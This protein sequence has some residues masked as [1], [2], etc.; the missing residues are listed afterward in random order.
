MKRVILGL[1]VLGAAISA[2]GQVT[3]SSRAAYD[4]VHPGNFVI[5]FNSAT[6]APP[7]YTD[8]TASTPAGN[9]LF[10]AI[11]SS[12]NIEFLG[13]SN[14]SFLGANNL[15]L[16]AFNGQILA[17]SLLITLPANTTTFGLD[18]ISPST[19]V[20]EIYK[21]TI[22]SG[23]SPLFTAPS[24]PSSTSGYTFFGFDSLSSPITSIALQI[25]GPIGAGE[26]T[27]DNFTVVAVPEPATI[28]LL[29][30]GGL[31]LLVAARRRLRK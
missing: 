17:D 11:P 30:A 1:L 29:G 20:N 7:Q 31:M 9:V 28:S 8:Y 14:F 18:L 24:L 19:T 5:D 26:P 10:D 6:P 16:Y 27:I 2:H 23:A 21:I 22:F 25:T 15:V 12:N 13:Q 4:L 3:Y